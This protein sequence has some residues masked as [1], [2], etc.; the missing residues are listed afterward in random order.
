MSYVNNPA[1][2]Q[3]VIEIVFEIAIRVKDII[4]TA[5]DGQTAPREG[6]QDCIKV[7]DH[8]MDR[9]PLLICGQQAASAY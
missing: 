3:S 6:H 5:S 9:P 4:P 8:F 2:G 1:R 7:L